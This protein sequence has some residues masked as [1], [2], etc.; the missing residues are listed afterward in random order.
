M[1]PV[2]VIEDDRNNI[3]LLKRHLKKNGIDCTVVNPSVD[4]LSYQEIAEETISII[5]AKGSCAIL[6]DGTWTRDGESAAMQRKFAEMDCVKLICALNSMNQPDDVRVIGWSD[7]FASLE[8]IPEGWA[9]PVEV[10][11]KL[12]FNDK[13][14]HLLI[15]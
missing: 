8:A 7:A 10:I 13:L 14:V 4:R 1:R 6:L 15:Q 11:G 5:E 2:I 9:K 3:V 12:E